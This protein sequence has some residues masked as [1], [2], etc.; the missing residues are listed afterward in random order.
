MSWL[1]IN[2]KYPINEKTNNKVDNKVVKKAH[3]EG[4]GLKQE[5]ISD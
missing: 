4:S 5:V 3:L 1:N 2:K